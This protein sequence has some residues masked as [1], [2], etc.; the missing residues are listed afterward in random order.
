[1]VFMK[2]Q[3]S[4]IR[5]LV[6]KVGTN[7]LT[8]GTD[9]L[10]RPG[11]VDL[12]RQ[13][14][15]LR[16]AGVEVVL[17]SS[18]AVTA[19]RERLAILQRQRDMPLKQL[20]A[21]VGQGRLMHIYEQIFDLYDVPVAQTLLT[22]DDLRDRNRYLNAR[23]TLLACLSHQV[24]PII[25]ENDVVAVDEIRVGDNDN[26]SAL[27]A[28]LVDADLLL[29]LSD[30][31]S[32]YTA[33]PRLD[34]TAQRIAEVAQIDQSI[35]DLAG[36]SNTRGTGGMRTKIQAADMATR[37]GT[38]VVISAGAAPNVLLRVCAGEALGTRFLPVA[39]KLESRKRW[40]LAETV[41]NS[42]IMTDAGAA[43][44]LREHG[45]SLLPA[46]ITAVEGS[47]ERGQTVRIYTNEGQE[48]ARGLA[49]Y[50]ARDVLLIKGLRSNEIG[51]RL[52]Y[53]YGPEVVHR[54]DMVL[55]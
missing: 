22:R 44:A 1:M 31:D 4:S 52:G 13:I 39:S 41:R 10:Y 55:L 25:N 33:D 42:R 6:V 26:L 53:D 20:L 34:P 30:I 51:E 45:R 8:N 16:R 46:G 11:M 49:Q 36:G 15:D 50:S 28:G 17:V 27:V 14:A 54:D 7:V 19:G 2:A 5:R 35:Y 3:L 47:F 21:A 12:A 37:S 32:L 40:L 23:N 48:I 9:R 29:I 38:S 24:L 43:R 18:G